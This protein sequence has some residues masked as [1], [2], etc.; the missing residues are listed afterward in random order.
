M[1]F[2]NVGRKVLR[3]GGEMRAGFSQPLRSRF[4][5]M[6]ASR[7]SDASPLEKSDSAILPI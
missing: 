7:L 3:G 5:T 1:E 4:I 6:P 2:F